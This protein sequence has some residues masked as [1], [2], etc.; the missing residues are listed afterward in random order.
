MMRQPA[1]VD[2]GSTTSALF[3]E[4]YLQG[5]TL[6]VRPMGELNPRTYERLRD[7]LYQYAAQ[8]PAAIV[9]DLA[10]MQA[11]TGSLLT[12]FPMV[13][14]RVRDWPGLPLV[15][16]APRQPLRALLDANAVSRSVP[17]YHSVHEALEGLNAAPPRRRIQVRLAC[18][19]A[20][21]RMAR[22]LIRRICREWGIPGVSANAAVVASE[23]ID[24]MVHHARSEGQLRVELCRNSLTISLAD[25]DPRLPQLRVPGLREV[26]GRGLVLVD[27][28]S[29]TWG[30]ASRPGG[31]KV[32]WAVLTVPAR[33]RYSPS[34]AR[35]QRRSMA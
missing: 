10:S 11:A 16:A 14:D 33:I 19:L 31:G 5:G 12:V 22:Q 18:D 25:A 32:V 8:E 24:N 34:L 21:S 27:K 4:S 15:L 20:S 2:S 3:L 30:T 23:L 7:G 17:T 1:G 6:M 26:G 35:A 28:L 9:V 13:H 29:R